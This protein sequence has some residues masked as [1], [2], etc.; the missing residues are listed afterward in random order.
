V[1]VD[2]SLRTM[3]LSVSAVTDIVG[4]TGVYLDDAGQ[5]SLSSYLIISQQGHN[6]H[7]TLTE[8]TGTGET[9]FDVDCFAK[10]RTQARALSNVVSAALKDYSGTI[11]GTTFSAVNWVDE[12]TDK[13]IAADGSTVNYYIITQT[14]NIFWSE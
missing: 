10:S 14:F 13:E 2:E 7:G 9:E 8:T 3:L 5:S 6:P 11:T 1:A 12:G 4:T